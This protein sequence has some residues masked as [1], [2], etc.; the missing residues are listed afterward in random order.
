MKNKHNKRA[1]FI[2]FILGILFFTYTVQ[3]LPVDKVIKLSS[4]DSKLSLSVFYTLDKNE[5]STLQYTLAK[6]SKT[7]LKRSN[8]NIEL[9]N[10][11]SEWALAIKDAPKEAWMNNLELIN[12]KK[13]VINNQWQ[14]VYGERG[15]VNNNY[16]AM[17]LSFIQKNNPNYLM[18]VDIR[19]YSEGLA[20][21][22]YFPDNPTGIYYRVMQENT[23]FSFAEGA[24]AWFTPWAQ[25]KAVKLPL[26]NWPTTTERPLTLELKNGL[27][28]ALTEAALIDYTRSKFTLSTNKPNTV[29]TR[30]HESVDIITGTSTPWRVVMV[31]DNA[32][33]LLQQNDILLN[34]NKPSVIKSTQ[35]IK[36]GKIV[37]DMTLT[38]EGAMAWIDF[39]VKHNLQYLLFDWKWYGPAFTFN[40]DAGTVDID[41]DLAKIIAYGKAKN[42]GIWLYVN[43]QALL[44][45]DAEI[46]PLYKKWGIAGVKYGFVQVGSHRWTAWLHDSIQRAADNELMVNIHDEFRLTGEQRTWPNI[47]TVEGIR[48]N[49]EMPS[50]T[51]NTI[52]PFTRGLAGMGDY[53]ICYY[54]DHIKT[55]HAHQ[56]ALSVVMYSPLQTLFWYDSA[57]QYNNEPE[58][59]FFEQVPTVWD[60]TII[61]DGQIGEFI[62]TARRSN[63]S[64]FIG[65]I[66][67]DDARVISVNFD[68]LESGKKYQATIYSDD[69]TVKT[70]TQVAQKTMIVTKSNTL[71]F[72]LKSAGGVAIMLKLIK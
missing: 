70:K 34:L 55:T 7:V 37:R 28:V 68:F 14:P 44:K 6:E 38:E 53:T 69:D 45:Q 18:N 64:W 35:W 65:A 42:I 5:K 10:H 4:P 72:S 21:K 50:A 62:I 13:N 23:E 57:K 12:I 48:G 26:K 52:V 66:T 9:D 8:F 63:D 17:T 11:L 59:A 25:G 51:S 43:Q 1:K 47:M 24:Q 56:L 46:F 32:A 33:Q 39:A 49:E 20:F 22:Y 3:A 41:L 15:L 19:L 2:A 54:S 60:D 58:I 31:A 30:M 71:E 29:V 36:P 16:S 27:Y 40:S 61:I 67:N